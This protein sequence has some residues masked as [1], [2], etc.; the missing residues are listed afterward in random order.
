MSPRGNPNIER[1]G[2][3][4]SRRA[5]SYEPGFVSR[6]FCLVL[7]IVVFGEII[8]CLTEIALDVTVVQVGQTATDRRR[9]RAD[10]APRRGFA[11][12]SAKSKIILLR[13]SF[14]RLMRYSDKIVILNTWP[15]GINYTRMSMSLRALPEPGRRALA[16]L[17]NT[18]RKTDKPLSCSPRGGA[19]V[20]AP[21][22]RSPLVRD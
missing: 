11:W 8:K 10:A 18:P 19:S 5:Q 9:P 17:C 3:K 7:Q 1:G 2:Q 12:R 6:A 14:G 15:H 22:D 13:Y 20:L 4:A 16:G 21:S